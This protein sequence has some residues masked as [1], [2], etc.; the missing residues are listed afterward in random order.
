MPN[1]AKRA[2]HIISF[3]EKLSSW[4]RW[5]V[6][7]LALLL[8]TLRPQAMAGHYLGLYL[9]LGL[10]AL[11]NLL[12]FFAGR[13]MLKILRA[14]WV[15][16][17]F[18]LV[19][20]TLLIAFTLGAQSQFF[21]L[22]Y[23]T[24][25]MAA[26]SSNRQAA[27][28]VTVLASGMYFLALIWRGELSWDQYFLYD[29]L[30]KIGLLSLTAFWAGLLSDQQKRWRLRNQELCQ[31]AD[32][33]TKTASDIQSA[34]LFGMGAL[35]SSSRNIEETLNL[36]LDAV[37]DL[38]QADRCSILLLDHDSNELVLR[39]SRGVRAG[40]V[41][42]LRLKS[43]Q[44][45]AGEVL[46]TGQPLNVPDTDKEPLFVPS[47]KHYHNRIRSMLVVP[48]IIRDRR[49]GVINISEVK[50][51]RKFNQSEL[52][53]MTLVASYTAVALENAGILEEKE[54]EATTDGLTGLHNY[55]YFIEEF[56]RRLEHWQKKQAIVSLI[57]L[58]LDF[59]KEY[60]DNFGHLKGSEILKRLG[61][62]MITAVGVKEA[63]YFRYGGDE[64]AVILPG[65]E[66][67]TA[68]EKAESIRHSIYH[69]EFAERKPGGKQL[70]ASIGVVN[71]PADGQEYRALIEKA[72]QAMYHAKEKGKNQVAFWQ[73]DKIIIYRRKE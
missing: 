11:Y 46:R 15:S 8:V 63:V 12:V 73:D 27:L 68:V 30:F 3:E 43:D 55:R 16:L 51:N 59:F 33:W 56:G 13:R 22:Y 58:D 34:A 36:T 17:V 60:N 45:I 2:I 23:L 7:F 65:V 32:E 42:K 25:F 52:A 47:P 1:R 62:I 24:I 49:I 39:A 64:F 72:D 19:F 10:A 14:L 40:A 28:K 21:Y 35:L 53:A 31:I 6:L 70:S 9:T 37:Q 71:C 38:L 48:L 4:V 5:A 20:A 41:G 18:D 61:D 54:K 66:N 26:V 44:G 69:T 57:W 29:L 50:S 67:Q